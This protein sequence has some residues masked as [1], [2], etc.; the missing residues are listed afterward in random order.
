METAPKQI[1]RYAIKRGNFFNDLIYREKV[2]SWWRCSACSRAMTFLPQLHS[3][4]LL[5]HNACWWLQAG[6]STEMAGPSPNLLCS[7]LNMCPLHLLHEHMHVSAIINII[8]FLAGS[9]G[10]FTDAGSSFLSWLKKRKKKRLLHYHLSLK[11]SA[12]A[13]F[14]RFFFSGIPVYVQVL[15][16]HS[17]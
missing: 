12:P 11:L 5:L 8:L 10:Y 14:S 16:Q 17:P 15:A 7:Y 13:F 4:A 2:P 9:G 1:G 3:F 6:P